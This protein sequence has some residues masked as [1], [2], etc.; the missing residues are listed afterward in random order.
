MCRGA[1]ATC[2]LSILQ[3]G[4]VACRDVDTTHLLC[5]NRRYAESMLNHSSHQSHTCAA[6]LV[7]IVHQ[8]LIKP[9]TTTTIYHQKRLACCASG[10]WSELS[11]A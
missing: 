4:G 10:Q 1:R 5:V 2:R 3:R 6:S 7:A 9:A 11:W 8:R